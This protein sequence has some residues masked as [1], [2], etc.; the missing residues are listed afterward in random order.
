MDGVEAD[1]LTARSTVHA[2]PIV[3]RATEVDLGWQLPEDSHTDDDGDED[4]I[5][6]DDGD[7]L[8]ARAL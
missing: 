1:M 8:E 5:A 3:V 4:C 7:I 6:L 2:A